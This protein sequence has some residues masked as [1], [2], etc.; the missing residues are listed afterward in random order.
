MRGRLFAVALWLFAPEPES[1]PGHLWP[2]WLF[3]RALGL[4]YFSA[5]LSLLGQIEGLLGPAGLL[6]AGEYLEEVRH[7]FG[8]VGYWF[9]P[10][11]FWLGSGDRALAF[12]CW[13]GLVA[14][15]LVV[16]N[17]WPR[18][19]L[20][21]CFLGF[22]SFVAAARD[23]SG[24]Q[25]DGMLLE[26]GLVA[27]FFAPPGLRPGLG[28]VRP[29][30]RASRFLLLWLWF[31]IYFESGWAKLA[32]GDPSWRNFTAMDQ[33]YQNGP[34]PTWVGWYVQHLPHA[35]HAA[36]AG[37]TLAVEL[38]IVWMMFLP[39]RLRILCFFIVTPFE[40][41]IIL[42][43][44]YCFLNYLVLSLGVLLLDDAFLASFGFAGVRTHSPSGSAATGARAAQENAVKRSAAT[45]WE[46]G[47]RVTGI[48]VSGIL[49]SWIFYATFAL[50][51]AEVAPG[52]PLPKSPVQLLAPFQVANSYGLFGR[53][54]WR[55]Y[56]IEFQGSDDG[57]TWVPYPF[58]FKPQDVRELPR[59]YAPYQPR[60]EWNLWFAM[61]GPL[62]DSPFVVRTEEAL[63]VNNPA[64]LALFAGNPFPG[65]PPRLVRAVIWQ[66]WFT[67]LATLRREGL[68]WRREFRGRFGPTLTLLEGGRVALVEL[69]G[70]PPLPP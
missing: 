28:L 57:E 51:A 10:T 15:A 52:L 37:L 45:L 65:R 56:E 25:S 46:R 36:T 61:L 42:T 20:I 3:L 68:W 43:A 5:F 11:L 59:I 16:L 23:F 34:L 41:G 30:S 29:P 62:Q 7:V 58:R 18:A 1:R 64:V 31:R 63:L 50:L 49:F 8:A 48:W 38:V 35:F 55:R 66:Y 32:S 24:Y 60:F 6:P 67:D 27:L 21:V 53:M 33:Y 14:S 54:T 44:N 39:R 19:S 17:I 26:A 13:A 47:T 40:M 12:L 9:A 4:I 22:L 70:Y 2:R 69:P